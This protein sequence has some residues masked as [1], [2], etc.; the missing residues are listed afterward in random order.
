MRRL[1]I[2]VFGAL[3]ACAGEQ[4]PPLDNPIE[5]LTTPEMPVPGE[6]S[7]L[8]LRNGSTN[9]IGYKLCT[10]TLMRHTGNEWEPVRSDRVCTMEIRTLQPGEQDQFPVTIPE[11]LTPGSYRFETTISDPEGGASESLPGMIFL[12]PG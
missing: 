4:L 1:M 10:S 2:L 3:C 5:L 12:I 7:I 6:E 9:P 8:T 11:G